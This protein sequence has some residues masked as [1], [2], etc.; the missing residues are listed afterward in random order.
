[1]NAYLAIKYAHVASVVLSGGGFVLRG[2]WTLSDSPLL[3]RRWVR[4]L[5]HVNDSLLL[6]AAITLCVLSGQYPLVQAWL[7]A[8]VFGLIAYIILGAIAL[9]GGR[10]M[11][12]R[13]ASGIAA[14]TVFGY[15][16]S[17]ALTKD[18]WGMLAML[19]SAGGS[20]AP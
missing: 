17:V 8:K 15:I 14:L 1:M 7:T 5:P 3:R 9:G 11:K 6:G 13:L 16:A 4:I 12:V 19:R 10:S 2:I 20:A 18:A